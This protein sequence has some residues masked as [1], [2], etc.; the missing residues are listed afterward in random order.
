M[1][2]RDKRLE[3]F[4]AAL[5]W[6]KAEG[7]EV[8]VIGGMAVGKYATVAGQAVLSGDLDLLA[9]TEQQMMMARQA[10]KVP[11]VRVE[12]LP[13]PRSAP[14]SV[15]R[16]SKS[17]SHVSGALGCPAI[18]RT[19]LNGNPYIYPAAYLDRTN[20][21]RASSDATRCRPRIGRR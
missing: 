10:V 8:V 5:D 16:G 9:T 11:G 3:D 17:R 13:Q 19:T 21:P 18:S 12:K 7:F 14:V 1:S 20:W 15:L 6:I 2:A 4:S